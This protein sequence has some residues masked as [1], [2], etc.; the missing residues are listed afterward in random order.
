MLPFAMPP[1]LALARS[2]D[3]L[4][5][6]GV[7][8]PLWSAKWDGWRAVWGGGRL[9]GRRG[10]DLTRY[11][12]D[13]VPV[14]A[15]RLPEN[16]VV[17]AEVVSWDVH[18]GRLDFQG[19]SRRLTAGRRLAAVAT[20]RPAHLVCFDLLAAGGI[21]L[22]PRP[23]TERCARLEEILSGMAAPIRAVPADRRRGDGGPHAAN[24]DSCRHRGTGHQSRGGPLPEPP[25]PACVAQA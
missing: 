4:R 22:R 21:D 7:L 16:V 14:L 12:P 17:D 23:L 20:A 10:T 24:V 8:D 15:A 25:E 19:L 6:A 9:W 13:L 3:V 2:T 5:P 1:P 11:F 18:A